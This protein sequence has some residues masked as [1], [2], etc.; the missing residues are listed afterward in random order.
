PQFEITAQPF[1]YYTVAPNPTTDILSVDL[2]NSSQQPTVSSN[3]SNN[4][5]GNA[6]LFDSL[7]NEKASFNLINNKATININHLSAGIYYLKILVGNKWE[8][9]TVIKH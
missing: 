5:A 9:H 1:I 4:S 3:M 8:S 7:G 6:K 2:K